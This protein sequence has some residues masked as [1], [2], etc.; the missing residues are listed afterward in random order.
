[1]IMNKKRKQHSPKFKATVALAA[2]KNEETIAKLAQRSGIVNDRP[3]GAI[4]GSP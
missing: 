4:P 2:I 1:M 3:Y